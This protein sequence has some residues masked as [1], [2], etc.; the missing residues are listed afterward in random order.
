MIDKVKL[1]YVLCPWCGQ[2]MIPMIDRE[3]RKEYFL[4]GVCLARSPIVH[5]KNPEIPYV[6]YAWDGRETTAHDEAMTRYTP[7]L[8]PLTFDEATEDDYYLERKGDEDIDVALNQFATFTLE[9]SPRIED[10]DFI[11]FTTHDEDN[12]KLMRRDYGK[13]WR[14]WA[15]RPTDEERKAVPWIV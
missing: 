4:C 12:L 8:V 15:R 14:C 7:P 11:A 5:A 1:G 2:S 9:G 10:Y 3:E 6:Y 13:T